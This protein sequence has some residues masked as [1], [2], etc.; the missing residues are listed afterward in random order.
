MK[1]II[2]HKNFYGSV[3]F[4]SD[5]NI[6][7]GKIEG[8]SDL[9]TFEGNTVLEITNSFHEAVDDY[10][11][12]CKINNKPIFKSYKGNFN[13]RISEELHKK[14]VIKSLSMGISLNQLVKKA[15]EHEIFRSSWYFQTEMASI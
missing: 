5:D 10:I 6:L 7:Y 4:D 15:I 11:E 8:I 1:D 3:H 13:I 9:V 14:A 12:I 2:E